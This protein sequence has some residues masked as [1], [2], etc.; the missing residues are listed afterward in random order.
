[1]NWSEGPS[2]A[3]GPEPE[4]ASSLAHCL[5]RLGQFGRAEVHARAAV[6]GDPSSE[7]HQELLA[8]IL[9]GG[10][11]RPPGSSGPASTAVTGAKLDV[12]RPIEAGLTSGELPSRS[13][14]TVGDSHPI[15]D[16]PDS[17]G[18]HPGRP[19]HSGPS[20]ES[21][22]LVLGVLRGAAYGPV[23][24]V[25]RERAEEIWRDYC[26]AVGEPRILRPESY[27]AA[28]EYAIAMVHGMDGVTQV[29]VARRYGAPP[30]SV[31]TRF[32]RI[33]SAL[34]LK[35]GDVRYLGDL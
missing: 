31:S 34:Q 12:P 27:A 17:P 29:S 18:G 6:A 23:S 15:V 32:G 13:L 8:W 16:S 21:Q 28:L 11:L 7:A 10:S 1:M 2:A 19:S 22:E 5:L 26:E 3:T 9:T 4:L 30:R 24:R 33:R 14:R 20:R 35:V 25:L